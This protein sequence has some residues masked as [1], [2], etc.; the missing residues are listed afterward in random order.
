MP[1][2][3]QSIDASGENSGPLLGIQDDAS[4]PDTRL[5]DAASAN[6]W[7]VDKFEGDLWGSYDRALVDFQIDGVAPLDEASLR[8]NNSG[9]CF[10]INFQ[11][12][13]AK[14][15]SALSAY[16]DI[17][18]SEEMLIQC[19]ID[20][21]KAPKDQ[22]D[23]W[24]RIWSKEYTRMNRYSWDDYIPRMQML[25][26]L[27]IRHGVGVAF[28]PN[29]FDWR[30]EVTRLGDFQVSRRD[31]ASVSDLECAVL[32]RRETPPDVYRWIRNRDIATK[33]GWNVDATLD[34]LKNSSSQ[35]TADTGVDW[36][37]WERDAKDNGLFLERAKD[38][39]CEI[40]HFWVKEFD[41]TVSHLIT[42]PENDE[43]FLFKRK[44]RWDSPSDTITFFTYG[45]GNGDFYSIRGL[46]YKIY[47]LENMFNI[48][49]SRLGDTTLR[50]LSYLWQPQS[51]DAAMDANQIIWGPD[52][53]IPQGIGPVNYQTPNI[54]T[55]ILPML[56]LLGNIED[57]NTGT[58]TPGQQLLPGGRPDRKSA[59]EAQIEATQAAVLTTSAKILFLQALDRLHR[60]VTKAIAR[61]D[62]PRTMPGG[63]L[64]WE[65]LRRCMD[66]GMP[67]EA[68]YG[69]SCV[70]ATR[71]IGLGSPGEQIQKLAAAESLM[72]F[73]DK[74]AQSVIQRKKAVAFLGP[75]YADLVP[76]QPRVP[77]DKKDAELE[78]NSFVNG[79]VPEPLAAEDYEVHLAE[80]LSFSANAFQMLQ[81]GE[82][83]QEEFLKRMGA[84]I[85]HMQEEHKMLSQ[86]QSKQGVAKE[87]GQVINQMDQQFQQIAQQ[88]ISSQQQEQQALA[89][90]AQKQSAAAQEQERKNLE[91]QA[92]IARKDALARADI[93]RDQMTA[94]AEIEIEQTKATHEVIQKTQLTEASVISKAKKTRA[95]V[96]A[97]DVTT[98]QKIN[99]PKKK[100]ASAE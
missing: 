72:P 14:I 66:Q 9:N 63:E 76:L 95:D 59:T 25:S 13:F 24:A 100:D 1:D 10:N 29:D 69:V 35:V 38:P 23:E 74:H 30:W 39:R 12:A 19:E 56:N 67:E 78:A 77:Q 16:T 28:R 98:T 51:A 93:E 27:F 18:D 65:M 87:L 70:R 22:R 53:I 81:A 90:E 60:M 43:D 71:P 50:S 31:G 64:R 40:R 8:A 7:A 89:A 79:F 17:S 41:G 57:F 96:I 32:R 94:E 97:K 62:Y 4:V 82:L 42:S 75:E 20:Y 68:F 36:Q 45:Q 26:N 3:T 99:A 91:T 61:R 85:P 49:M 2:D 86:I 37:Q 58:Y 33:A 46:G 15:E 48:L 54:G 80:H 52:T 55:N 11:R 84:A 47:A 73:L 21:P 88:F 44:G 83:P 34:A 5:K 92:D 6:S